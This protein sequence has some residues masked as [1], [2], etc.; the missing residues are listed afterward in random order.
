MRARRNFLEI[1]GANGSATDGIECE[2]S[3]PAFEVRDPIITWLSDLNVSCPG[4][5]AVRA[6][7]NAV[8]GMYPFAD[9]VTITNNST[10]VFGQY[11]ATIIMFAVETSGNTASAASVLD[12]SVLYLSDVLIQENIDQDVTNT[13]AVEIGRTS[14]GRITGN[15]TVITNSFID[16]GG[17]NPRVGWAVSV[18]FNSELRLQDVDG[19][20]GVPTITG[21]VMCS[22]TSN[23]SLRGIAVNGMIDYFDCSGD[24]RDS[25]LNGVG[26]F[27]AMINING[28]HVDIRGNTPDIAQL[29]IG[30]YAGVTM[31]GSNTITGT[32]PQVYIE[33][34]SASIEADF[35]FSQFHANGP[36][37]LAIYGALSDDADASDDFHVNG[38]TFDLGGTINGNVY[39]N[40]HS[41]VNLFSGSVV[42]GRLG[43][44]DKTIAT[45]QGSVEDCIEVVNGSLLRLDDGVNLGR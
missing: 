25:E 14:V 9:K 7:R 42:N 44:F 1:R 34:A 27:D 35:T 6:S 28:G 33:N 22:K 8:L 5:Y 10:G 3:G 32:V 19:A 38:M 39:L 30:D 11:G 17:G 13:G 45:I 37:K 41:L 40:K 43:L 20:G 15:N 23:M 12:G 16:A 21:A 36:G 31:N 26:S 4:E 18:F 29:G 2:G 24:F